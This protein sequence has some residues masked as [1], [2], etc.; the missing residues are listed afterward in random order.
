MLLDNSISQSDSATQWNAVINSTNVIA[1]KKYNEDL[2]YDVRSIIN[3]GNVEK[4]TIGIRAQNISNPW[5]AEDLGAFGFVGTVLEDVLVHA[6][7]RNS[8]TGGNI[9]AAV[10]NSNPPT[11][12]SPANIY[13]YTRKTV[14][15][16]AVDNQTVNNID[17]IWNGSDDTES[18]LEKSKWI[19]NNH[20]NVFARNLSN[21]MNTNFQ[22]STTEAS[23]NYVAQMKR[24]FDVTFQNSFSGGTIKV[25]NVNYPSPKIGV[26]VVEGNLINAEALSSYYHP[27]DSIKYSFERWS[28]NSTSRNKTFTINSGQTIT[29]YYKGYAYPKN[30]HFINI[31]PGQPI[32]LDWDAHPN[33]GVTQYKVWRYPKYGTPACISTLSSSVTS[34]TDYDYVYSTGSPEAT[35][36]YYSVTAYYSPDQ[37]WGD[38]VWINTAGEESDRSI[39]TTENTATITEATEQ[40]ITPEYKLSNSPNPF[41][42]TTQIFYSLPETEQVTIKVFNMLGKEVTELVNAVQRKG[43]HVVTFNADNLSSGVYIYTIQTPHFTASKKMI[44]LR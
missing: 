40:D 12:S 32:C 3:Q 38:Q 28:D 43:E 9:K 11:V 16:G 6:Y 27:T 20:L 15:V 4:I 1:T 19:V 30:V 2:T 25:K 13:D 29:A 44:L 8:F 5:A 39:L 37:T 14:Y 24:V 26:D 41:N 7:V 36:M 17:Y 34:F 33:A 31:I 10:N 23:F 35:I 18:P 21:Y 22:L 42:P